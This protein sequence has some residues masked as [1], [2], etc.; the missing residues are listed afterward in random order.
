MWWVFLWGLWGVCM[1]S[2]GGMLV[3]RLPRGLSIVKPSSMCPACNMPIAF[4][5]LLPV[6]GWLLLK[7][8]CRRCKT[9]ISPRYPLMEFACGL[10]FVGMALFTWS[11]SAIV[12]S[13][14]GFILLVVSV[15]DW[16]TQEIPDGLLLAAAAMGVIWIVG[17]HFTGLFPKAPGFFD[18]GMGILAGAVPLLVMDRLVLALAKKDGF[19]YGDVK[20]MAVAGLYLG[21]SATITAFFFAFISGGMYAVFLRATGRAGRDTY[22]AFGPFLCGGIIA[23]LWFG[24]GFW[25][26]LT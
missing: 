19:G 21:W 16:D 7:G 9:G 26:L 18:A 1:G 8:R 6:I 14:L 4:Y 13:F 5:D 15:I 22:I 10:L 2:F 24:Q 12:L 17:G 3:Y 11:F 23:A 20:L 25:S